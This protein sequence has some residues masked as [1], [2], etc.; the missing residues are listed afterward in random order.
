MNIAIEHIGLPATDPVALKNWYE[1]MLGTRTVWDSGEMPP[2]YLVAFPG[3]GWLEIYAA[4][5]PQ[6]TPENNS[7]QGF[8]HLALRV[9]SLDAAKAEAIKRGLVFTKAPG[10]AAGGGKVQYFADLEGNLLHFV[11]RPKDSALLK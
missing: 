5:E 3:G 7:L 1:R 8:R 9:D 2:A 6:A 4:K 10:P 11:E